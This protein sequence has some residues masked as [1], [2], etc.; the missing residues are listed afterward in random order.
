MGKSKYF[1]LF[2]NWYILQI[3]AG[4]L[5][6]EHL[7]VIAFCAFVLLAHM[8]VEVA[9]Q[10]SITNLWL[11]VGNWLQ[12]SRAF[13]N[14]I[15]IACKCFPSL[16]PRKYACRGPKGDSKSRFHAAFFAQIT[17]INCLKFMF[18]QSLPNHAG[19]QINHPRNN[20]TFPSNSRFH[21]LSYV[22]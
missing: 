18:T 8:I 3:S 7:L 15:D 13:V 2:V 20:A 16:F 6:A 12:C 14:K 22:E 17:P 9:K 10:T 1:S 21:A 11:L 19:Y 4:S 5:D